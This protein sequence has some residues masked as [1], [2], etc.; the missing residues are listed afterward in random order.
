MSEVDVE[1]LEE[2]LKSIHERIRPKNIVDVEVWSHLGKI[3]VEMPFVLDAEYDPKRR[4]LYFTNA[5]SWGILYFLRDTL[6][7]LYGVKCRAPFYDTAYDA[8]AMECTVPEDVDPEKLLKYVVAATEVASD[9]I[10]R[11]EV[12]EKDTYWEL[13]P[14]LKELAEDV[15]GIYRGAYEVLKRGDVNEYLEIMGYT[16]GET[17]RKTKRIGRLVARRKREEVLRRIKDIL[18]DLV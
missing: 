10:G 9:M 3:G 5:S 8:A 17:P 1:R 11:V 13:L 14:I 7:R 15:G 2:E 4:E 18:G 16:Y 6:K 12:P